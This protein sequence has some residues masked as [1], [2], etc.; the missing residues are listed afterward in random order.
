[1]FVKISAKSALSS[2][3]TLIINNKPVYVYDRS[4][5]Y[6]LTVI[7]RNTLNVVFD[8]NFTNAQDL[9][10]YI[11]QYTN[12]KFI[13]IVVGHG[14]NMVYIKIHDNYTG[15]IVKKYGNNIVYAT[16]QFYQTPEQTN[17]PQQYQSYSTN[18]KPKKIEASIFGD[19]KTTMML[20]LLA[21]GALVFIDKGE[22]N[23]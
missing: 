23:D 7:N 8:R 4:N 10:N 6:R 19:G 5:G 13:V 2:P 11:Q 22:E 17:T 12:K 15:H 20:P 14:K 1:M 16:Y 18:N 9:A 3:R 21:L